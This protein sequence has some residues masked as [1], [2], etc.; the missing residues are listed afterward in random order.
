MTL[1]LALR[2]RDRRPGAP[3]PTPGTRSARVRNVFDGGAL[4]FRRRRPRLGVLRRIPLRRLLFCLAGL[5]SAGRVGIRVGLGAGLGQGLVQLLAV[6]ARVVEGIAAAAVRQGQLGG[7]PDVLLL[8][9]GRAAPGCVRDRGAGHHQIGPH[10]V[11][12]ERRAQRRD[13]P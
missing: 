12:V 9:G 5:A 7:H 3:S 2:A 1:P 6:D 11:H 10:A 13:A 8:D 4:G